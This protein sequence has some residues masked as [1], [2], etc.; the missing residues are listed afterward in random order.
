MVL[1]GAFDYTAVNFRIVSS[2]GGVLAQEENK[3]KNNAL[4]FTRIDS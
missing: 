4:T 1:L 2:D 3:N